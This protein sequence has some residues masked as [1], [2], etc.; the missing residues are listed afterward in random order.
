MVKSHRSSTTLFNTWGN[1]DPPPRLKLDREP[2]I[3]GSPSQLD[4]FG[5]D[6]RPPSIVSPTNPKI[7][8][9]SPST[10]T[11]HYLFPSSDTRNHLGVSEKPLTRSQ[12]T[13]SRQRPILPPSRASYDQCEKGKTAERKI[14][15]QFFPLPATK[16]I[17][18]GSLSTN[19]LGPA[20]RI[21]SASSTDSVKEYTT[22]PVKPSPVKL[23]RP[24]QS[25]RTMPRSSSFRGSDLTLKVVIDRKAIKDVPRR[26]DS[27][28]LRRNQDQ[29]QPSGWGFDRT[30][31]FPRR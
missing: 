10:S 9:A 1:H 12:S 26:K 18:K 23:T 30:V 2:L 16:G 29:R 17:G 8:L 22:K 24:A 7:I 15:E 14:I 4:P 25:I 13:T 5:S 11:I 19:I 3:P 28:L 21:P 20:K 31:S 6:S 27:L